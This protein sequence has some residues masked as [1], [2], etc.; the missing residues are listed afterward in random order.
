[1]STLMVYIDWLNTAQSCLDGRQPPAEIGRCQLDGLVKFPVIKPTS[2]KYIH[3]FYQLR[4]FVINNSKLAEYRKKSYIKFTQQIYH[5]FDAADRDQPLD[6][7]VLDLREVVIHLL[8]ALQIIE[9]TKDFDDANP[10]QRAEWPHNGPAGVTETAADSWLCFKLRSIQPCLELSVSILRLI[11]PDCSEIWDECDASF[12]M[13]EWM[14]QFILDSRRS[15]E[16]SMPLYAPRRSDIDGS[17]LSREPDG[18]K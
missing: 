3:G 16:R 13:D 1:M 10:V 9:K 17:T 8:K 11:F 4:F 15:Q 18:A 2:L 5:A 7:T 14:F 12:K 6:G